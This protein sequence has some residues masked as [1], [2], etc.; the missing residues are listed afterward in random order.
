MRYTVAATKTNLIRFKKNLTLTRE[1]HALLDEKRRILLMEL[2]AF[3]NAASALERKLDE[4]LRAAYD[5]A[6]AAV[7]AMGAKTMDELAW[8]VDIDHDVRIGKRRV[9]GVTVP[10]ITLQTVSHGPFYGS[11]GVSAYADE[12]IAVFQGVLKIIAELAGRKIGLLRLAR[13]VQK[14]I[15]KVNALEKVHMPYFAGAVTYVSERLDEEARDAFSLLKI[16]K[17]RAGN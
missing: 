7:I 15:R 9:M 6:D 5:A 14:T 12:T 8:A 17:K 1:G 10:V 2:T 16:I 11:Q 4:A 13:E 3:A